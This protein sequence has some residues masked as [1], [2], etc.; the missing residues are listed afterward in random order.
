MAPRAYWKGYLRLSLVSCP[1]AMH[2]ASSE[3]EKI[4]F[5]QLNR[6]TGNRVRYRKVD[7]GTGDEV[8][9]DEIIKGYE[10]S[11]GEYVELTPEELE[12]AAIDSTRMFDIFEFVPE[13]EID[14]LYV[15]APYYIV[16]DGEVGAQAFAVIRE[17]IKREGMVA[18]GR[19]VFTSREHIIALKSRGQGL[20]GLTLRYPYE[21]RKE[22]EYFGEIP[23]EQITK[24]MLDL[25]GHIVQQKRGHFHPEK[26][27]DQYEEAL[28]ELLRKKEKGERIEA[29]RRRERGNVINLMDALRRSA[30]GKTST[31]TRT[32][33]R[34]RASR[35]KAKKQARATR[36]RKAG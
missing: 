21:I 5:H 24:E 11:K 26:F 27:K 1:I 23:D 33:S 20:I 3:R 17:A 28:R 13:K 31:D 19:V 35:P 15:N 32:R 25:A 10:V 22:D 7:E 9:N 4:R 16:P 8:P 36:H 29:P 12:A 6:E 14:E 30:G 18:L 34:Q 2:P